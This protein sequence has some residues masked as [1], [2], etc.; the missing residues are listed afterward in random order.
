MD[1]IT[2][3]AG[4]FAAPAYRVIEFQPPRRLTAPI[5]GAMGFGVPAAVAAGLRE[6]G[7]EVICLVGNGGFPI[8]GSELAVAI[9]RE[10]PPKIVVSENGIYGSIGTHQERNDP[11]RSVGAGF[12]N[13]DFDLIGRAHGVTTA[14]ISSIGQLPKLAHILKMPGLQLIIVETG[15]EAILPKPV[16][17]R[18]A[19]ECSS[20]SGGFRCPMA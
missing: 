16:N 2:L 5:L 17:A 19:E 15:V 12:V 1:I 3:D 18:D 13:P 7:R 20:G 9:E 6:P 8:A 11:G 4:T 14:C 10:L